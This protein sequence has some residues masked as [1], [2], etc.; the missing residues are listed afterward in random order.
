MYIKVFHLFTRQRI[1]NYFNIWGGD[2]KKITKGSYK[3]LGVRKDNIKMDLK[4]VGWKNIAWTD[5]AE[6]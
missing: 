4:Q 2:C 6:D 1:F 5:L 3:T